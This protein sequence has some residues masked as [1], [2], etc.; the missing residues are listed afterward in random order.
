MTSN[1]RV[2]F[3]FTNLFHIKTEAMYRRSGTVCTSNMSNIFSSVLSIHVFPDIK[4][5]LVMWKNH[6]KVNS[7]PPGSED[8]RHI[9]LSLMGD[10]R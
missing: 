8:V 5:A 4:K 6:V 10:A 9:A 1:Q 3:N 7:R 2:F